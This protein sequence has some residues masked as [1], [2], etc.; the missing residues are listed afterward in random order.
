[1]NLSDPIYHNADKAREHLEALLWPDG[2]VCPHCKERDRASKISGGRAG[3]YFCNAC[4][5]QFTVTVGTVFERSKLPLN[6]WVMAT[7]FM[8]ASKTGISAHQ[9]HRMLGITYKSAWFMCHRIREAMKDTDPSPMGGN[10]EQV[11]VDETYQGNTSKRAKGYKKGHSHKQQVVA[12]VEPST[13]RTKAF[14]VKNA[15]L[16]KVRE[17]LVTNVDRNAI[18]VSDESRLY[19]KTGTEYAD[20]Q[21]VKHAAGNYVNKKG[22]HTNNVEN[23]FG[24]FKRSLKAHIKVSEQHLNRYAAESA[25]RYSNRKIT[26]SQRAL[27]ALKGIEGKRLTYRPTV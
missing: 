21:T 17:I 5:E 26:D 8:S 22:F 16:K 6:K 19:V 2:P 7:H 11:Q 20:H 12:L 24:V 25:F 14:H 4:R 1:M 18:L 15:T 9:L 10:G 23:F 27:E 13:G 3:L